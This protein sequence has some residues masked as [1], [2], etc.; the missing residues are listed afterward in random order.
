MNIR[1]A[2]QQEGIEQ[3]DGGTE[4]TDRRFGGKSQKRSS[5]K[6]VKEKLP[7]YNYLIQLIIFTK[8]V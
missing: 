3:T 2:R 5:I 4:K 1:H 7:K 6:E 8:G